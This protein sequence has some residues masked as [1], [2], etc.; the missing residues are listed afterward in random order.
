MPEVSGYWKAYLGRAFLLFLDAG[1]CSGSRRGVINLGGL[2]SRR[3][4]FDGVSW[5]GYWWGWS[6]VVAVRYRHVRRF[7]RFYAF[8]LHDDLLI[9]LF[10]ASIKTI[11]EKALG[12]G[13]TRTGDAMHT[14]KPSSCGVLGV[15]RNEMTRA[16]DVARHTKR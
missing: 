1:Y 13:S 11:N 9:L 14:T 16:R 5:G 3:F 15:R 4:V 6:G 8:H 7:T 10:S 2:G 12:R